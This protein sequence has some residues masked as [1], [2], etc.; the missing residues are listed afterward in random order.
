MGALPAVLHSGGHKHTH[1]A[2]PRNTLKAKSEKL[3]ALSMRPNLATTI[4]S[5]ITVYVEAATLEIPDRAVVGGNR[6]N[7]ESKHP[8]ASIAVAI[9][10][11]ACLERQAQAVE[12]LPTVD[13]ICMSLCALARL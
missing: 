13:L 10:Q 9:I 12:K 8:S 11:L 5:D 3:S 6:R 2:K 1:P 7:R 4:I